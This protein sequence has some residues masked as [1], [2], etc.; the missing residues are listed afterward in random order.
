MMWA[1]GYT[2]DLYCEELCCETKAPTQYTGEL[3][4]ACRAK[5]R[6]DGWKVGAAF[7]LGETICPIC[8]RKNK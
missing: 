2:L 3:G 6:R 1:G 8:R 7:G 5:A 4:S